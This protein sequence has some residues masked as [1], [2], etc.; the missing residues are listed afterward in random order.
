MAMVLPSFSRKHRVDK[1]SG[2]A[3]SP[4]AYTAPRRRCGNCSF[5][6]PKLISYL[7]A[8]RGQAAFLVATGSAGDA[9]PLILATGEPVMALG[10]F[11]A[12]K[13]L[14]A[15]QL[16]ARVRDGQIR[17]FLLQGADP[18]GQPGTGGQATRMVAPRRTI[19]GSGCG[20]TARAYRRS[21]GNRRPGKRAPA[22]WRACSAAPSCMTA[23]HTLV[24]SMPFDRGA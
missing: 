9:S 8:N 4:Q 23:T 16:A 17:F 3:F 21:C 5:M 7:R 18:L 11:G 13:I 10:G 12:D 6:I 20:S 15:D 24:E 14:T 19:R 22:T 1:S 2:S